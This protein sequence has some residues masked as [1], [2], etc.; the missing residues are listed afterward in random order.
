MG[1]LEIRIKFPN[2]ALCPESS[3]K[4]TVFRFAVEVVLGYQKNN[5]NG[6]AEWVR[7]HHGHKPKN[8]D[9]PG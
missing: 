4:T 9:F 1:I 8:Q 7:Y 6:E 3:L 5:F 2:R